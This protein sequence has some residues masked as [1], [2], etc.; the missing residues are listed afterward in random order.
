[1]YEIFKTMVGFVAIL[2][3]GLAGV[4]VSEVMKL[5]EMNATI[6]TVDNITHTR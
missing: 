3:A 6:M 4:T 1:M 2:F 5:G